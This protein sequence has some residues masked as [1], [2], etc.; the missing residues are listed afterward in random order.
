MVSEELLTFIKKSKESNVSKEEVKQ[1]LTKVGWPSRDI[2]QALKQVYEPQLT[3]KKQVVKEQTIK[4][5]A[6]KPKES[7]GVVRDNT[8]VIKRLITLL[9]GLMWIFDSILQAQPRMFT[10][11][12]IE[13]VLKP[14]FV[15]QPFFLRNIMHIGVTLYSKDIVLSNTI[16]VVLEFFIGAFLLFPVKSK[17]V[18]A[19]LLLT[20][21]WGIIIWVFGEGMGGLFTGSASFYTGAPGSAVIY[22]LIASFLLLYGRR[23]VRV[24][25]KIGAL[26]FLS[27][28]LLQMQPFFWTKEGVMSLFA[29]STGDS[30]I[31]ISSLAKKAQELFLINPFIGNIVLIA[32]LFF[33]GFVLLIRSNA[34]TASLALLFLLIIWFFNQDL[35]GVTTFVLGLATDPNSAPII[36]LFLL[37]L[38][39]LKKAQQTFS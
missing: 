15:N 33:F 17:I 36:A 27:G 8:L 7:E 19:G 30:F 12:F 6:Q 28:A 26:F 2:E 5:E 31:L 35:G 32:L 37:P 10:I 38:F 22:S 23:S 29:A 13:G 20:I 39:Y 14:A 18:T 25:P 16:A 11:E 9:L 1:S 4:S 34:K 24:L 21:M 3:Q